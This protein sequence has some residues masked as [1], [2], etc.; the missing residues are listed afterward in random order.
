VTLLIEF[1]D[2]DMREPRAM[3]RVSQTI[4]HLLRHQF[5]H[6][7]DRG[8]APLLEIARRPATGPL[9]S[10]FFDTAGYKLILR[11]SEGWAG[12]LPDTERV[13]APRMRIEETLVLLVLARLWQ[14]GIQDGEVGERNCVLS[15][16]NDAYDAYQ[17]LASRSRRASLLIGAFREILQD[18]ARRAIVK[19]GSYDEEQQDLELNIRPIVA[20]VAGEDF[21]STIESFLQ[22]H[23]VPLDEEDVDLEDATASGAAS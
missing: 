2:L 14:E 9:I 17:D 11:E 12:I 22:K 8:S 5:I 3:E 23:D 18:L 1:Q 15:T 20:L 21:L 6:A 10:A 4:H 19:L 7:D 16:L 13:T